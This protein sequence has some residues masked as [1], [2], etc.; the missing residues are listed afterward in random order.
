[1]S[2][3]VPAPV[4]EVRDLHGASRAVA[5]LAIVAAPYVF[6]TSYLTPGISALTLTIASAVAVLL[7]LIGVVCWRWP[8]LMPGAFWLVAP[9]AAAVIVAGLNFA[10]R[11]ASTGAQLFYLWPILY[12]A[13]FL[14]RRVLYLNLALVFAGNA[15]TVFV[16]LGPRRGASD[17]VAMVLAMT[18]AA[19]VVQSLRIRADR[20]RDVLEQQ[21][22]TDHLT[23]LANRRYF[24][25]ALVTAAAWAQ[26]TDGS[27]ALL[28]VDLDHF[29]AINDTYGHADG[30]RV[31]QAVADAMR[32]VAG[33]TGVAARLG[34]DEFVMLLRMGRRPAMAAADAVRAAVAER[35]DLPGGPPGVSIG[36]AVLPGD[37]RTAADLV[38]AS[39]TALYEAKTSGRGRTSVAGERQNVDQ[40]PSFVPDPR[41]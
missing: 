37:A 21:A 19:T 11:D 38:A 27:L 7:A 14:G 35:Y 8:K 3:R 13:N 30:D 25:E 9:F 1:V 26:R 29:K 18:M 4:Y 20:L 39:D 34:G 24:D 36:L 41:P 12:T 33:E 32:G 2:F 17:W 23:G 6:V 10:T 5:Y 40:L 15:G 31:L 28:T 16:I 22:Y